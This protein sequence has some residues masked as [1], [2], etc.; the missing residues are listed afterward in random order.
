MW[1]PLGVDDE[2]LLGPS[3]VADRVTEIKV[4]ISGNGLQVHLL[5]DFSR[6]GSFEQVPGVLIRAATLYLEGLELGQELINSLVWTLSQPKQ[7]GTC[8]LPIVSREEEPLYLR[9]QV[10]PCGPSCREIVPCWGCCKCVGRHHTVAQ[11]DLSPAPSFWASE[12][13]VNGRSDL[14]ICCSPH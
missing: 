2:E 4:R 14:S 3:H 8:P 10:F 6:D 13:R 9:S 7:L 11:A 1:G 12:P 5:Q